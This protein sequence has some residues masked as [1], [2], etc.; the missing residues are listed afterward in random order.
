MWEDELS[1]RW[2]RGWRVASAAG[3]HGQGCRERSVLFHR[4]W[5]HAM[6]HSHDTDTNK[7]TA[8]TRARAARAV[9][10][11]TLA[12]ALA[13]ARAWARAGSYLRQCT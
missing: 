11:R 10:A 2:I 9:R 5:Y 7:N 4:R 1:E 6:T 12:R 3:L 8:R 13:C